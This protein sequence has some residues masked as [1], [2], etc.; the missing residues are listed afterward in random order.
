MFS[1]FCQETAK[2]F[3]T[4][5]S[6][7]QHQEGHNMLCPSWC[8]VNICLKEKNKYKVEKNIKC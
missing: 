1:P 8:W 3:I 5:K 2:Q 4:L 7:A 6:M